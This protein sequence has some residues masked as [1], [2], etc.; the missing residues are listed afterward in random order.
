MPRIRYFRST[1]SNEI[2][3]K[4]PPQTAAVYDQGSA[5]VC[6][7]AVHAQGRVL[8]QVQQPAGPD[9]RQ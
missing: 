8:A 9:H 5:V 3:D 2:A 6:V 7:G 4:I 1:Q